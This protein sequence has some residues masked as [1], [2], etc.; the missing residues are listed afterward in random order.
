MKK[1]LLT[2]LGCAACSQEIERPAELGNTP[3]HVD[4]PITVSGHFVPPAVAPGEDQCATAVPVI[5]P[6]NTPSAA[7][8]CV[9]VVVADAGTQQQ[10]PADCLCDFTCDCADRLG[11]LICPPHTGVIACSEGASLTVTCR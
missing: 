2:L 1:L 9:H 11:G 7:P 6:P 10:I 3:P 4:H 5:C 8:V